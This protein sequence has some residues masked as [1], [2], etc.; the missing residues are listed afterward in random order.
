MTSVGVVVVAAGSGQRLGLGVPKAFVPVAGTTMLARA[1]RAACDSG[2]DAVVAVVP[3]A[4]LEHAR[5]IVA[6]TAT[7]V[8]GGARRQDSVAAGL[9]ALPADVDV[10]L[11]H[12]AA[13][14]LAP[15]SLFAEVRDAVVATGGAVVPGL[16]LVDT[17]KEVGPDSAEGSPE[18]VVGTP[19]RAALR[20]VQTPQGFPRDL[21][22]RAH[23]AGAAA[24]ADVTD[25]A[26]LVE[27]LGEP[28]H[29]VG[30]DERALKVTRPLDL[31]VAEALVAAA[32]GRTGR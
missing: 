31:A 30:G 13:R 17:V 24:G 1:V 23:E 8:V 25:D 16:P 5:E 19:D 9:A 7:A 6:G 14:C 32:E 10:V 11:V 22:V 2:A 28:V 20:V 26:A 29:V 3:D 12:D 4:D 15:A 27:R 21:L 18:V